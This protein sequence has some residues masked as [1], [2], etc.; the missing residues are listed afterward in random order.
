VL[1]RFFHWPDLRSLKECRA[2]KRWQKGKMEDGKLIAQSISAFGFVQRQGKEA[3]Q[4]SAA[5]FLSPLDARALDALSV[6]RSN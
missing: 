3:R 1:S 4:S 2:A 6:G 5:S